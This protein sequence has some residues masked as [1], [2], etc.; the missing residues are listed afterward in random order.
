MLFRSVATG[1][2]GTYQPDKRTLD[3]A[4]LA[5][6]MS[7]LG[8]L[9]QKGISAG[10]RSA[11]GGLT[12][13]VT[14]ESRRDLLK[15]TGALGASTAIGVAGLGTL[16]K[17]GTETGKDLGKTVANK[18]PKYRFNSLDE[19]NQYLDNSARKIAGD[20]VDLDHWKKHIADGEEM[21]YYIMKDQAKSPDKELRDAAKIGRAHV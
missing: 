5:G 3:A 18:T 19:Y 10:T 16:R 6:D 1:G 9:A 15:K 20:S 7:A 17:I 12:K 13:G 4:F 8:G 21:R 2:I 14:D 11:I